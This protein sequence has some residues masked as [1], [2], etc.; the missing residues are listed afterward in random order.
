MSF[1]VYM[2]V[3]RGGFYGPH[4]IVQGTYLLSHL[5]PDAKAILL[6]DS[7]DIANYPMW[8]DPKAL[9]VDIAYRDKLT[10]ITDGEFIGW[11]RW[12][13]YLYDLGM[14]VYIEAVSSGMYAFEL[15]HVVN[16]LIA[17]HDVLSIT[18][19]YDNN[20]IYYGPNQC[21]SF[22][23]PATAVVLSSGTSAG[24]VTSY[25]PTLETL[26]SPEI[27]GEN[28]QSY[29]TPRF[30]GLMSVLLSYDPKLSI[31]D[32][33]RLVRASSSNYAA[34]WNTLKG[35]GRFR[36]RDWGFTQYD[37]VEPYNGGTSSPVPFTQDTVRY[38]LEA[39]S[40]NLIYEV[41][42][43]AGIAINCYWGT[44]HDYNDWTQNTAGWTQV[45]P[46]TVFGYPDAD[47]GGRDPKY[48]RFDWM[49]FKSANWK[50]TVITVNDQVIYE[51]QG[52]HLL[53]PCNVENEMTVRFYTRA[54]NGALSRED[55]YTIHTIKKCRKFLKVGSGRGP[56]KQRVHK[57][58]IPPIA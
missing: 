3:S 18:N 47:L 12:Y 35:Y 45:S 21:S 33:R 39:M 36:M 27:G 4:S 25:G 23:A 44:D 43:P 11:Q 16:R 41:E 9:N 20:N 58:W 5:H 52:T 6:Y 57:S 42:P 32:I 55:L 28:A 17:A 10:G 14:R 26:W 40:A 54:L 31:W 24:P 51:G 1:N 15:S 19:H 38:L 7:R 53:W 8:S 50:S 13:K 37:N 49:P 22:S 56:I 48:I 2:P 46:Q 34:G 30:A 29:T